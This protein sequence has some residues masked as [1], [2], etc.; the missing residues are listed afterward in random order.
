MPIIRRNQCGKR[1]D[2]FRNLCVSPASYGA[3]SPSPSTYVTRKEASAARMDMGCYFHTSNAPCYR[4][5]PIIHMELKTHQSE[6]IKMDFVPQK[7]IRERYDDKLHSSR[8]SL[9]YKGMGATKRQ[10]K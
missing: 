9:S 8:P 4:H 10:I 3:P 7:C 1:H 6:H 5:P 2:G